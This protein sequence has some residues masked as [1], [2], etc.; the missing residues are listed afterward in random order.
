MENDKLKEVFADF[1]PQLSSDFAFL[2]NVEQRLDSVEMIRRHNAAVKKRIRKAAVAAALVGFVTG[3]VSAL[4]LPVISHAIVEVS[5][6]LSIDKGMMSYI[7]QNASV[8]AWIA[9]G[10]L[11]VFASLNVYELS[12]AINRRR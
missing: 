1:R 7:T 2:K 11:S 12:M 8:L 10:A 3:A 4:F 5:S 6:A 9:V